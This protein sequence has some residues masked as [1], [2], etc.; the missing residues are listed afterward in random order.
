MNPV[1]ILVVEDEGV[2]ALD[3][4]STL[5]RL[6]YVVVATAVSGEEAIRKAAEHRPDLVLMDVRLRGEMD[7]VTAAHT[8]QM[9]LETPVIYLTA[10]ADEEILTR[11]KLTE[12]VGYIIKP[13]EERE[14]RTAVELALYKSEVD[15][16]LRAKTY[17]L[18]Q[19]VRSVP[20]G[21]LLLDANLNIVLANAKAQAFL[22]VL[23]DSS[24][25]KKLSHLDGVSM[26]SILVSPPAGT[27]HELEINKPRHRVFE[28][29][30]ERADESEDGDQINSVNGWV[31]VI[32]DVTEQRE[33]QQRAQ[34]QDRLAAV[35]QLS[36]GI[37]HDFNNIL[38]SI[39]MSADLL[40]AT[41]P[42]LSNRTRQ[43]LRE[44]CDETVRASRLSRQLLDF[45]RNDDTDFQP[46]DLIPLAK[47]L[48]KTLDRTISEAIRVELHYKSEEYWVR[49]VA[50]QLWEVVLN[51]ALNARDAMATGGIL[52]IDLAEASHIPHLADPTVPTA[53][54]WIKITFADTGTG[55]PSEIL[56]HI[57]E[58]FFTTKG[59]G[60]GT[61]L[62]LAQVY[63]IVKQHGGHIAVDTQVGKGTSFS[64]YLPPLSDTQLQMQDATLERQQLSRGDA[65]QSILI[66]ED[67][68]ALRTVLS[69]A[70]R[71]LNYD[72]K[73]A[74]DG[75]E[76]L[77]ILE[78]HAAEIR[79][80][81]TDLV[82]PVL[83]GLELCATITSHYKHTKIIV[84]T[85]YSAE[86]AVDEL[87]ELDV[88][89]CVQKPVKLD[90]LVPL[91]AEAFRSE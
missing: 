38:A 66:V 91:I 56:P 90:Q 4:Q 6:G 54:S 62:G 59:P 81:V 7:G 60:Q 65:N 51:L 80:V 27:W 85:G 5:Q 84:M 32:R 37:A 1:K 19:V 15:R 43:R 2:V 20:E 73:E 71:A 70:L 63:G 74:A 53:A 47:E 86:D 36:A 72:V 46:L 13:F 14:L 50:T 89:M 83:G 33:V 21:I 17:Q 69:D 3:I 34:Q 22:Q 68:L 49:G 88:L 23:T 67:N 41:E 57:F 8:I 30:A 79:L 9:Q 82:M 39:T 11:A 26:E 75:T 76:A 18:H 77:Q 10:H 45:S 16:L 12:P 48:K 29:A 61:G 42:D 28:V 40:L 52:S 87:R 25:G 35:G 55:I 64:V 44:I 24:D 78:K 31:V 58:P